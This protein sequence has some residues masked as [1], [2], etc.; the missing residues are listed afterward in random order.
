M[1]THAPPT[2][3]LHGLAIAALSESQT[4]EHILDALDAGR[5]GWVV[6]ANLAIL[7]QA[8]SKPE[9][10]AMVQRADL[11]VGDGMPLVW[12]SQLQRT[13]LPERVAGSSMVRTLS[14]AAARRGRSIYL[15][16]GAPGANERA[17]EA[18]R[19]EAPELKLAGA[20][21]PDFGFE[22]RTD[23]MDRLARDLRETRPDIVFVA[24][25]FPKQERVIELLREACPNAWWM[26]V[27]AGVNFLAGV[28]QRA[29]RWM[30]K[31]GLEW[32][33]RLAS[34]PR[35]LARRYLLEGLPFAVR[36]FGEAARRRWAGRGA[37]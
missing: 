21:C 33:H 20:A 24:L 29:P 15:L 25:G 17:V 32:V 2:I 22:N 27:G 14:L 13:P 4:I 16:G 28:Q 10:R 11:I 34:E 31:L 37:S 18:L 26:G 7:Q 9:M 6:T 3:E 30:Q 36:L 8:T 5:G 1:S 23:E 12:A 35:R 19:V